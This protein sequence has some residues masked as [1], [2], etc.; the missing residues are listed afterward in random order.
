[1]PMKFARRTYKPRTRRFV[2][3]RPFARRT[4]KKYS[5]MRPSTIRKQVI[6][7]QLYCK[8]NWSDN[9]ILPVAANASQSYHYIGNGIAPD[10]TIGSGT[11]NAGDTML[12]GLQAYSNL[13]SKLFV[14]GS[15]I[16][17]QISSNASTAPVNLNVSFGA[18]PYRVGALTPAIL[19]I[20]TLDTLRLQPGMY[21]RQLTG[22]DGSVSRL[23]LSRRATTKRIFGVKDI[24]DE[25][26]Y[27]AQ[28]NPDPSSSV[29]LANAN[30]QV[31]FFWYL[32]LD[33]LDLLTTASVNVSS[34][35]IQ[36]CGLT[37][38]TIQQNLVATI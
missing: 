8:L 36:S 16:Q 3:R 29:T 25:P 18:F 22:Y 10:G 20:L 4:Y 31:Q 11:I 23:K 15:Y 37:Q 5:V 33:N 9:F 35:I 27:G 38:R 13:F 7:A 17:L 26:N 24:T 19:D 32:R 14:H 30:P 21:F 34:K 2:K 12:N 1:M 6:G 28:L